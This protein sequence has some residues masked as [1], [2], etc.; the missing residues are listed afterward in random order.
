MSVGV[1]RSW[2]MS[3]FARKGGRM[4]KGVCL[5]VVR[6]LD[7]AAEEE[8]SSGEVRERMMDGVGVRNDIVVVRDVLS[9]MI[10]LAW[11]SNPSRAMSVDSG[12]RRVP[13]I[14]AGL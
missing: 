9:K 7:G 10:G 2:L 8:R 14:L 4:M 3:A 6:P 11:C 12:C 5:K 1:R 13:P